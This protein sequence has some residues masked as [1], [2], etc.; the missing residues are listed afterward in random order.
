MDIDLN[1]AS[2]CAISFGF[3]ITRRMSG[4][5]KANHCSKANAE[6]F[7]TPPP[8][9][10]STPL[11]IWLKEKAE[12]PGPKTSLYGALNKTALTLPY[13]AKTQEQ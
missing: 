4:P 10:P 9:A 6:G 2:T 12:S 1:A 8:P 7:S 13:S 3:T 11:K 5:D